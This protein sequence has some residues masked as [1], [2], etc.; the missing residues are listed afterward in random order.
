M[1]GFV[2]TCM[3]STVIIMLIHDFRNGSLQTLSSNV[4]YARTKSARDIGIRV[5]YLHF[6]LMSIYY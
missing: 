6:M 5:R 4:R 3:N 2:D 1:V